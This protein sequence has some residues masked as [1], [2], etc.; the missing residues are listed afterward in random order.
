MLGCEGLDH[1]LEQRGDQ[2]L[3]QRAI[4]A[5][6]TVGVEAPRQEIEPDMK[7]LLGGEVARPVQSVLEALPLGHERLDPRAHRLV[8]EAIVEVE[9]ARR[10]DRSVEHVRPG[11]DH[12]RQPRGAAEHVAEQ[13]AQRC[14][15]AQD[16]QELDAGGH[17]RQRFVEGGK[18]GVGVARSGEGFEQRRRQFRQHLPRAGAADRRASSEVPAANRL[19][20]DVR[21]LKAKRA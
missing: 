1:A 15:R 20:C 10:I 3:R 14:V 9:A 8:V 13:L 16:R 21:A 4:G 18:R 6:R 7:R 19:R 17:A 11:R 2:P 5:A 12:L